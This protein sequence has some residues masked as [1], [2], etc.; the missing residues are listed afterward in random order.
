MPTSANW[1][2]CSSFSSSGL[3]ITGWPTPVV[4]SI[5]IALASSLLIGRLTSRLVVRS[6]TGRG[7]VGIAIS[8]SPFGVGAQPLHHVVDQALAQA[9]EVDGLRR[10]S[11]GPIH[12]GAHRYGRRARRCCGDRL[13]TRRWHPWRAACR[14]T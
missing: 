2:P 8:G 4:V 12:L 5:R 11:L 14:P 9:F 3:Y 1:L 13:W 6:E 7:E 10:G